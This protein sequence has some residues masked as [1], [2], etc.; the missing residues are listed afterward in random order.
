MISGNRLG[1]IEN[2]LDKIVT[3][4]GSIMVELETARTNLQPVTYYHRGKFP[5]ASIEDI[6]KFNEILDADLKNKLEL[7]S[8]IWN[9][10]SVF[11]PLYYLK[12]FQDFGQ[13]NSGYKL[14]LKVL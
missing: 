13:N 14:F 10:G 2:K 12:N 8:M 9:N 11:V 4:L 6:I 3:M 7:V 5:F 1:A